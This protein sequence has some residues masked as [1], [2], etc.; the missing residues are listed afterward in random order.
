MRQG[1]WKNRKVWCSTPPNT[2]SRPILKVSKGLFFL[3]PPSAF[4]EASVH[5][6]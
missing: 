3:S 1:A 4:A 5:S 2:S 6:A